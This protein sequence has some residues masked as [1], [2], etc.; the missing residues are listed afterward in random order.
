M[1]S[2]PN[3]L[4]IIAAEDAKN[5]ALSAVIAAASVQLEPPPV[6]ESPKRRKKAVKHA[7]TDTD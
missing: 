3:D 6:A 7:D 1:P 2:S 5:E 4:R